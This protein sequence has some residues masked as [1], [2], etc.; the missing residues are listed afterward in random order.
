MSRGEIKKI[1]SAVPSLSSIP[2]PATRF[3][4]HIQTFSEPGIVTL[5][6]YE[7]VPVERLSVDSE[8]SIELRPDCFSRVTMSLSHAKRL[9]EALGEQVKTQEAL[10]EQVKTQEAPPE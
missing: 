9:L 7:L 10:G 2:M 1:E 6:F 4:N 3:T 8:Q 5:A